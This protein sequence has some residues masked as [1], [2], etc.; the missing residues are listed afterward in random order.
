VYTIVCAMFEVTETPIPQSLDIKSG[1]SSVLSRD[2]VRF[3]VAED[4]VDASLRTPTWPP[5]PDTASSVEIIDTRLVQMT[6]MARSTHETASRALVR[7]SKRNGSLL[8]HRLSSS[9]SSIAQTS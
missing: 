4:E 7:Y 8:K 5:L 3:A 6:A 9:V 2:L 1:L